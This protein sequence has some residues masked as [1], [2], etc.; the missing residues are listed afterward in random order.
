[1][2]DVSEVLAPKSDQLDNIELRGKGPQVFTVTRVDVREPGTDQP[3]VVHLAEF[4]RPWKPGKT[5]GR[6]LAHCWGRESDNWPGKRVELF[7][8]EKVKFGND[9]PGGTRISRISHITEPQQVPVLLGQ[10]RPGWYKVD[11]LPDAPTT[12][13]PATLD[14]QVADLLAT[15]SASHLARLWDARRRQVARGRDL[16]HP[17]IP[18]PPDGGLS[19]RPEQGDRT[20]PALATR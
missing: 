4:P 14:T 13:P 7:A 8:D 6:V 16:R 20:E 10:G 11:P 17:G 5:M 19:E 15:P 2:P 9:T 1:M 3:L 18:A 12:Q